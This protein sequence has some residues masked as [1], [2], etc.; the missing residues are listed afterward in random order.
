MIGVEGTFARGDAV[1]I[2]DPDGMRIGYGVSNYGD[3]DLDRIRGQRSDKI[4]LI[5]GFEYGAEAVHRNN[6]VLG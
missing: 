4:A 6:L 1:E 2:E 5:L 3:T